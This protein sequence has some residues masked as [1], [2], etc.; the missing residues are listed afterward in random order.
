VRN[1]IRGAQFKRDVKLAERRGKDLAKLRE[2]IL[3]LAEGD[4]L[5]STLQDRW[6]HSILGPHGNTFGPVLA[7]WQSTSRRKQLLPSVYLQIKHRSN[8]R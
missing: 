1:L 4:S 2:I 3:L 5:P 7:T 6:R 8:H